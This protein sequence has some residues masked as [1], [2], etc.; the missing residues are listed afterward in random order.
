MT[1]EGAVEAR[2][3]RGIKLEGEW[4]NVSKFRPVALPEVGRVVRA[5]VDAKGFIT[6]I[7]HLDGAP[8]PG[9]D[10]RISRL[11]VLKAAAHF[12]AARSDIKSADVLRIA[13]AWLAWVD[14]S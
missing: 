10:Q 9:R 7:E 2:N 4:R 6:S 12:A 14:A 1:L 13:D 3:E 8:A 11:T 5:E